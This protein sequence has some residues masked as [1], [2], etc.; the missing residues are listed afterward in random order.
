MSRC[1]DVPC[2]A[3]PCIVHRMLT[4]DDAMHDSIRPPCLDASHHYCVH[5][6]RFDTLMVYTGW[7][8][9]PSNSTINTTFNPHAN[10]NSATGHF[11]PAEHLYTTKEGQGLLLR[12]ASGERV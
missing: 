2:R 5:I 1:G 9:D 4:A 7:N 8:V 10:Q 12:N 11:L 6:A 3:A